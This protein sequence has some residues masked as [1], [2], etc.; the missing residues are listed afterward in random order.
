M[1]MREDPPMVRV[2]VPV[3]GDFE[4][5]VWKLITERSI[6]RKTDDEGLRR[7]MELDRAGI[8]D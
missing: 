6:K 1:V 2:T 5:A 7:F 3:P 4:M 8:T